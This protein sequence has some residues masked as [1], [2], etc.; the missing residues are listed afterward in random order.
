[1]ASPLLGPGAAGL[2]AVALLAGAAGCGDASRASTTAVA[3]PL[4]GAPPQ[5]R[6]TVVLVHQGGWAGPN[7]KLQEQLDAFPGAALR[8][9]GLRT[10]SV[11]Y[12][13]GKAGL[14]DVLAAARAA[15]R[16][17]PGPVCLYGESA[18]GTLALLAAARDPHV[19]CV[20]TLGAPTDF[21]TWSRDAQRRVADPRRDPQV[22]VTKRDV[23]LAVFGQTVV[24]AFGPVGPGS[25][26]WEPAR[27]APRIRARVVLGRQADDFI[28]PPGQTAAFRRRD[29]AA[30]TLVTPAGTRREPY[31]HGTL[32]PAGREALV[33]RV[34]ALVDAVR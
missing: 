23:S 8:A 13:R 25:R 9:R 11:D 30:T 12:A 10:V 19:A 31:L 16:H 5:P 24:P 6:G 29:P 33:A 32:G 27:V 22:P 3:A 7:A 4:V 1:M 17:G 26:A 20:L 34:T 14:A 15:R 18:G 2:A 21:A 28:V